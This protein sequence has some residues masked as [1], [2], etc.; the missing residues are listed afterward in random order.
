MQAC[1][2]SSQAELELEVSSSHLSQNMSQIQ[3]RHCKILSPQSRSQIWRT[4]WVLFS[5]ASRCSLCCMA[6]SIRTTV[7]PL[8]VLRF[9]H[10]AVSSS[11]MFQSLTQSWMALFR[12]AYKCCALATTS[13]ASSL[14]AFPKWC[15]SN[16]LSC[17]RWHRSCEAVVMWPNEYI[18]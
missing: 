3:I 13:A 16:K 14:N 2:T 15:T 9:P 6:H 7:L 5:P 11:Q 18:N 17:A 4:T 10:H 1:K 8:G 12:V